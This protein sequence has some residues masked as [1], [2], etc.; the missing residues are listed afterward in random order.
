MIKEGY[1]GQF[2]LEPGWVMVVAKEAN[3]IFTQWVGQ[4]R[5]E[6]FPESTTKFFMKTMDAQRTFVVDQ[7]GKAS[8]VILYQSGRERI[9]PRVN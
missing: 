4:E 1:V 3:R 9:A 5:I 6:I 8:H 7:T 2:E